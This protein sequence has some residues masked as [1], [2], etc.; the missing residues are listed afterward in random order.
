MLLYCCCSTVLHMLSLKFGN[1]II[2]FLENMLYIFY[3][4]VGLI[5]RIELLLAPSTK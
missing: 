2:E 1:V 5:G 3:Y 4:L